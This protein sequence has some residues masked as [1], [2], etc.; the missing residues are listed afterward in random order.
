MNPDDRI[1][2]ITKHVATV[3]RTFGGGIVTD[4]NNPIAQ[5]M[6]NTPAAFAMGVDVRQV[7][8]F[9]VG[10]IDGDL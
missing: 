7:V 1:D 8:A 10:M 6:K 5:A 9:V 4:S 3:F 2:H